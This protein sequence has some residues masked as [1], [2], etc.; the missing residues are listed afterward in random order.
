MK[1]MRPENI[2]T[3]SWNEALNGCSRKQICIAALSTQTM[4][5]HFLALSKSREAGGNL[6]DF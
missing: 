1:I 4:K 2:V 3:E 5:S 6:V